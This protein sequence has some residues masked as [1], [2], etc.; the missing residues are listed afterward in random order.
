M[1]HIGIVWQRL[2]ASLRY[3]NGRVNYD[4]WEVMCFCDRATSRSVT[5]RDA[6][7]HQNRIH[8]LNRFVSP[9]R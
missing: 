2:A 9:H 3:E 7:T 1:I 8:I 6:V 5:K 4:Y